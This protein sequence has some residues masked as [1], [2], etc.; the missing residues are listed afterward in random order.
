MSVT[1]IQ[2]FLYKLQ[3]ADVIHKANLKPKH[4]ADVHSRYISPEKIPPHQSNLWELLDISGIN[5]SMIN[6]D[7]IRIRDT[8]NP[9]YMFFD[10][11]INIHILPNLHDYGIV[12]D[13][14]ILNKSTNELEFKCSV[15]R[16]KRI[17][18]PRRY[19]ST[20]TEINIEE[21]IPRSNFNIKINNNEAYIINREQ[22]KHKLYFSLEV[23]SLNMPDSLIIK[24]RFPYLDSFLGK[25]IPDS[26]KIIEKITTD[27]DAINRI[28]YLYADYIEKIIKSNNKQPLPPTTR[29]NITNAF[30]YFF[31]FLSNYLSWLR[32]KAPTITTPAIPILIDVDKIV[33]TITK[34]NPQNKK[35]LPDII[36]PAQRNL[37]RFLN[38]SILATK[39]TNTDIINKEIDI[40]FDLNKNQHILLP[41][42]YYGIFIDEIKFDSSNGL[43]CNS[44]IW[45]IIKEGNIPL[46]FLYNLSININTRSTI[47]VIS[48]NVE[49]DTGT[50]ELFFSLE[51]ENGIDKI[52]IFVDKI[53]EGSRPDIATFL[54]E[55]DSILTN[56]DKEA[57][58]KD[59]T[60]GIKD[61][62]INDI[63][64][65]I[66]NLLTCLNNY[67]SWLRLEQIETI[68]NPNFLYPTD[69]TI[70]NRTV[71]QKYIK[72]KAKYIKLSNEINKHN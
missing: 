24:K 40:F 5:Q 54:F 58:E 14:I 4:A 50:A 57:L 41:C 28:C 66:K 34:L 67:L 20:I 47:K 21:E 63:S 19:D 35:T 26:E 3:A 8:N 15:H 51:K 59:A 56:M 33:A 43:T 17:E 37:W 48:R 69:Q 30:L 60:K 55:N 52:V 65:A 38:G 11:T 46:F 53:I 1:E 18:R 31:K 32:L 72:Y 44:K 61:E 25:D 27:N 13:E 9:K 10:L 62:H 49:K 6:T 42:K 23:F 36:V 68:K 22:L 7:V 12:V 70:I 16:I 39:F 71:F 64:N 45:K 2:K 29:I